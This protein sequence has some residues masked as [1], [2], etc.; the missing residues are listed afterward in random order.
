M[1]LI[2]RFIWLLSRF[3][4]RFYFGWKAFFPERIP[5]NGPVILASNHASYIDPLLIGAGVN[6]TINFLARN[7]LYRFSPIRWLLLKLETVPVDR[8]GA[9]GTGLKAILDRLNKGAA[10][11]LFVEGTRSKDGLLQ[12]AKSGIG[13]I[14][15]KTNAPVIPIRLFGTFEAM[16]RH[17]TFPRPRKLIVKYGNPINFDKLRDEARQCDKQRLKAIYREIADRIMAEIGRITADDYPA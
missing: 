3:L 6:R 12:Q 11:L 15:I 13:L 1:N 14:V 17:H 4:F 8:D 2:Y 7:T 9:G 10:I 16:G 5:L